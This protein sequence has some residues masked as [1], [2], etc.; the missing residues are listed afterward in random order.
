MSTNIRTTNIDLYNIL[1]DL[2]DPEIPTSEIEDTIV[3]LKQAMNIRNLIGL[4][5][6]RYQTLIDA[7]TND[8]GISAEHASGL[9]A[10]YNCACAAAE[11]KGKDFH[12][13]HLVY[14]NLKSLDELLGK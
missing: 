4:A 10:N 12:D 2:V 14:I 9:I 7:M 6:H 3:L 11:E 8:E 1:T 5:E 13:N